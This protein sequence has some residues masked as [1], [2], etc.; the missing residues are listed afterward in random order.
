MGFGQWAEM[1]PKVGFWVQ[2]WVETHFSHPLEAQFGIF[3]KPH[4]LANLRGVGIV[5]QNGPEAVPTQHKPFLHIGVPTG[6]GNEMPQNSHLNGSHA[7]GQ[8][9]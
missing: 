1:G 3:A 8:K 7:M 4:F 5:S 6:R 9:R 2:K